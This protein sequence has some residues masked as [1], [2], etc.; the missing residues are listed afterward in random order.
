L[1]GKSNYTTIVCAHEPT[2][3]K[4]N[5]SEITMVSSVIRAMQNLY[6]KTQIIVKKEKE[7]I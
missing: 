4:Y 1:R 2:E 6:H 3:G 5:I 7:E